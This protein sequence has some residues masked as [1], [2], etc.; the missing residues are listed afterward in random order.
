M[1]LGLLIVLAVV[2]LL[3][4][5]VINAVR[6]LVEPPDHTPGDFMDFDP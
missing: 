6:H 4:V 2:V 3:A 1:T 5:S